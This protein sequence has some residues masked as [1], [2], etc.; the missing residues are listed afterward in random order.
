MPSITLNNEAAGIVA[1]AISIC[2]QWRHEYLLP[3]HLA[4]AFLTQENFRFVFNSLSGEKASEVEKEIIDHISEYYRLPDNNVPKDSESANHGCEEDDPAESGHLMYNPE[5]SDQLNDVFNYAAEKAFGAM[6]NEVKP[7]FLV[8][9]LFMLQ[10]SWASYCLVNAIDGRVP[11]FISELNSLFDDSNQ[12]ESDEFSGED[13]TKTRRIEQPWR[14]LVTCINDR[15]D[16]SKPL[17]GRTAELER[18]IRVL[19]RRE[20]NNPLHVG[21]PGVGK[22]AL[23]YGLASLIEKGEVPDRLKNSKIYSLDMGSL[24]AGTQFRGDME[25]R[26]KDVMDGLSKEQGAIVYID[27]IHSLVGAGATG[28]GAMDASNMLKPYLEAGD[29]RFIGATTYDEYKRY[30]EKSK[31]LVRRFQQI[32]IDEPSVEET[33]EIARQ[34]IPGYEE[35]HGVKYDS[36]AVDFAVKGSHK[37]MTDRYLPDKALDI[38]DEAGAYRE[39]HPGD[40]G[41]RRVDLQLVSDIL[42]KMCK[43]ESVAIR[44]EAVE[45]MSTLRERVEED[46]YGQKEAVRSVTEAV[47]MS[48]AGLTDEGKPVASLLFVGPTGVGKTEL[49]RV[50]AKQMGIE[51]IRFDMSEY[52][53]KHAVAKLIGAPAGYVGYDDGGLLVDAIRRTPNCVLLLDEIEKAHPDIY[54]IL[55]QVMDY[56]RLTDNRGQQA[57]FRNVVLIMTSNAGA[58]FAKSSVGFNNEISAGQAMMKEVRKTFKP[59]FLNRLSGT[60]IFHDMDLE[61][62][63]MILEKKLR[64]LGEKMLSRNIELEVADEAKDLLLKKGFTKDYGARELDRV[65]SVDLKPL[66]MREILYGSLKN[67]GKAFVTANGGNLE[68]KTD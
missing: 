34:L 20:K 23:V 66:L 16:E 32:D 30:F 51:L 43:V 61:M 26:I 9:G 5:P 58:Q 33:I 60:A 50:L 64:L 59:E 14:S 22:T 3:E 49:A 48:K 2:R 44:D 56:A 63:S 29:I 25:K 41:E 52:A 27:E 62:A 42:S 45:E 4:L 53:E 24:L 54:N 67:G 28:Q 6:V 21:H 19:C 55:L 8:H 31:S 57:D 11:D 12:Q 47:E 10:D 46:I 15:L 68:L 36:D 35:Y 1:L 18:T 37:H 7:V 40:D 39:I 38:I 13:Q 17:I 65:I